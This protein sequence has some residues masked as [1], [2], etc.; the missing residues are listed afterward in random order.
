[1]L[2]TRPGN[3]ILEGKTT[4]ETAQY[5]D[6][7]D[8]RTA[9]A[10]RMSAMYKA[11]VPL[12][13][14]LVRIVSE[15]NQKVMT[16]NP[17]I[18]GN[19]SAE[20]LGVERHGAIR[21]GTPEELR[22]IRRIF[23]VLGMR[24][25]G[26]YDL[27]VA[28][29]P[30]HATCFRP[31]DAEAL[32]K[33]PFRVFTTLLRPELLTSEKARKL[34][35]SLLQKRNIFT[36]RLLEILDSIDRQQGRL[37]VSQADI[38]ITEALKTF[39]WHDT[40]AATSEEYFTLK[41]EHPILADIACFRSSH[42]NHLTPRVLDIDIAD[43]AMRTAGM[44]VKD[45]IEGP[46]KRKN[47]ILLRQTSFL[48]LEESVKF[49]TSC[50]NDALITGHH[51]ARFGEIEERGAALTPKG[52]NLYDKLHAEAARK[53]ALISGTVAKENTRRAAFT[54]FPD[55][56]NEMRRQGLV[57]S[58]Y[59]V[60][61]SAQTFETTGPDLEMWIERGVIEALPITYEDFLPFSAAGIFQSNLQTEAQA[62]DVSR[63]DGD[64]KGLEAAL[65]CSVVSAE[66]LYARIEE[67]S[68]LQC[69]DEL[70]RLRLLASDE[71]IV[72]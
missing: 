56:W 69:L 48:A 66:E 46:P 28:G 70:Q 42:I 1:M 7:N 36:D 5:V 16:S 10:A 72:R 15:V 17:D 30:M 19:D 40:A 61:K 38:F 24:A 55:A 57:Y 20:R 21:V 63:G 47:P 9:F 14:D 54:A 37:I 25:V 68:I 51:K 44:A 49:P 43:T 18:A 62:S 11:E 45:T 31:T 6:S 2:T 12:Y 32:D 33:N 53:T 22:N 67:K 52:R 35:L 60:K 8:L 71:D 29:L 50:Q 13:G 64:L 39:I 3:N 26:Y 23:E 27:S 59:R 41:N 58:R 65:G 34:A 4:P